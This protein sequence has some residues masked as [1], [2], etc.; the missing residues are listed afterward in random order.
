MWKTGGRDSF[1]SSPDF[2]KLGSWAHNG[3][4]A[5]FSKVL[6][7]HIGVAVNLWENPALDPVLGQSVQGVG[8]SQ[9]QIKY[10]HCLQ[11]PVSNTQ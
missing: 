5:V 9:S 6:K 11:F 10:F 8:S 2:R 3:Y 1:I 7:H 4:I